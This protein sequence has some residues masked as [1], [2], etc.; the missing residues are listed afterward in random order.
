M[1]IF[2]QLGQ[3]NGVGGGLD[4]TNSEPSANN[5]SVPIL[6]DTL[7]DFGLEDHSSDYKLPTMPTEL[8][9]YGQDQVKKVL[10]RGP[11]I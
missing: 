7:E 2:D 9:N 1:G 11:F 10:E 3:Q 8:E 6:F 5:D 4:I